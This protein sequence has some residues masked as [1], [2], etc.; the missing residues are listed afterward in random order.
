MSP[1]STEE[2]E[3]II[4]S[5]YLKKVLV[6]NS[7][8]MKILKDL[9]E[10]LSKPLTVLINLTF[11]LGI[12]PNCLKIAKVIPIFKKSDKQECNN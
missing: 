2:A 9:K 4:S 11:S 7:V 3:D 6:P 12:L 8:S 10:E 1:T 5:F